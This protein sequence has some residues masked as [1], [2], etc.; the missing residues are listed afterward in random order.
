[1][2]NIFLMIVDK[3]L[4]MCKRKENRTDNEVWILNVLLVCSL[5]PVENIV[6]LNYIVTLSNVPNPPP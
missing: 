5:A 1:M 3:W 4:F 2:V 6:R